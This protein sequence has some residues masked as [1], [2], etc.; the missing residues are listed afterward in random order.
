MKVLYSTKAIAKGGR[1]G[2]VETLDGNFKADLSIPKALGGPGK[3]GATNPEQ[4]FASGYAAC[5]ESAIRHVARQKKMTI[6]DLEV[7]S[8]VGLVPFEIGFA[9]VVTLRPTF[10]GMEKAT[11]MSL[12]ETAH[13]VCPYSNGLRNNVD[14]KIEVNVR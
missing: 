10:T 9:L 4:L 1:D 13:K 6:T 5:F 14:V 11:A 12:V 2:H 3:P 7:E 8:E